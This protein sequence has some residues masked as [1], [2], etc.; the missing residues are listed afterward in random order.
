MAA[1]PRLQVHVLDVGEGDAILARTPSGTTLLLDGGPDEKAL[2]EIGARLPFFRRR[3][4]V[5]A[6]T[7]LAA[8]R[9]GALPALLRRYEVG[10]LVLPPGRST[11]PRYRELLSLAERKRIPILLVNRSQSIALDGGAALDILR[12]VSAGA[13]PSTGGPLALRLRSNGRAVL[14]AGDLAAEQEKLLAAAKTGIRS[15]VLVLARHGGKTASSTGFLLAV[16]PSLAVISV[17]K[18]NL[19]RHPSPVILRRLAALGI[20]ARRTD[21]EGTV[22]LW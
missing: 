12:P 17:G 13:K 16:Q 4:D 18:D 19:S 5:V 1:D 6:L 20:P 7:A 15:D 10:L 22:S 3:I 11:L 2:E 9:L 8:G 14:L 21:R